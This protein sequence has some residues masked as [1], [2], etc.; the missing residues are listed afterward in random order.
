MTTTAEDLRIK[1][2]LDGRLPDDWFKSFTLTGDREELTIT[3]TLT[4]PESGS[5]EG[6]AGRIRRFREETRRTRIAIAQELE[7]SSGRK[8]TWAATCGDTTE[9]FT[10]LTVPVMTRL[11]Q[12]QRKV[13]D[14]LVESGVARSRSDALAW[15]V[16]LVEEHEQAWLTELDA[17]LT[18]VREVRRQGPKS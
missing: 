8:V 5:E 9:V 3:G 18:T 12:P 11:A 16:R 7:Q 4:E 13:L 10:R 17:A 15:C 1:D 14:T 2:W 6:R